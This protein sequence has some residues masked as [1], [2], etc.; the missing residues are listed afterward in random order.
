MIR[1]VILALIQ[2][3]FL[4][5]GQVLLKFAMKVMPRFAFTA[6]FFRGFFTNWWFLGCGISFLISGLMWMYI[7]KHWPLSVA[8]PL[9]S[10]SYLF[11][12]L[13]AYFIFHEPVSWSGWVGVLLI[14]AGCALVL[15]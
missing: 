12:T 7:L 4:A 8:Y 5:G 6:E 2:S 11:G 13:A 15:R 1:L 3:I 14:M 10:L 9:A